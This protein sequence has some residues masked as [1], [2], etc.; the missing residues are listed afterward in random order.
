M[1][2]RSREITIFSLSMM[3]VVTGAMGAFLIVMVVLARYYESDPANRENVEALK[4]ELTQVRDRLRDID[5]AVKGLDGDSSDVTQALRKASDNLSEAERDAEK[6]REQLDQ[7]KQEIERQD[8]TIGELIKQRAFAVASFWTC[9]GVDVDIYVWDTQLAAKDDAPAPFFDPA[10]TQGANWT[11]DK[12]SDWGSDGYE[13]WLT[14]SSVAGTLHKVYVK[15][16]EPS[17]VKR[18]CRVHTIV[19][20]AAGARHY[21]RNLSAA[22][23]WVYVAKL[24]QNSNLEKGFFEL[25]DPSDDEIKAEIRAVDLRRRTSGS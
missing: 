18:P 6:L 8:N 9:E 5:L 10:K 19:T 23:P 1:R 4:A 16:I 7:A 22:R 11:G 12:R 13:S 21:A 3:D 15:L 14:S 2:R 20:H 24:Q 25:S 17:R